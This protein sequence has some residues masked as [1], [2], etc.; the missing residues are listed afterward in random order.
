[1]S[2]P[3]P[4]PPPSLG[5]VDGVEMGVWGGGVGMGGGRGAPE[6]AERNDRNERKKDPQTFDPASGRGGCNKKYILF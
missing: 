3:V 2:V 6:A 1:M 4:V 5:K